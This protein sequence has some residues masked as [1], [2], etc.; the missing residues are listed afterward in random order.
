MALQADA[1][2]ILIPFCEQHRVGIIEKKFRAA[3][4]LAHLRRDLKTTTPSQ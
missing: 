4:L 3:V 2:Q 1:E